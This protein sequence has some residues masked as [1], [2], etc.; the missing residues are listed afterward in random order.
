MTD[1]RRMLILGL[2]GG[3]VIAVGLAAEWLAHGTR[4]GFAAQRDLLT[5]WLIGAVGLVAWA[6]VPRS[7]IGPLLVGVGLTWFI[8]TVADPRTLPGQGAAALTFVYV[9]VLVHAVLTWPTGR[10]R[11]PL[12]RIFVI[13]GYLLA[14]F[15]PL[16]ERD[17]GLLVIAALL[18]LALA[19]QWLSQPPR[20]R[21]ARRP[22]GIVGLWL[23]FVLASK[24]LVAGYLRR[25]GVAYPGDPEALWQIALVVAAAVLAWSLIALERRRRAATDL[26]VSLEAVGSIPGAAVL[27]ATAGLPDE[28]ST[29]EALSRAVAMAERNHALQ[30]ELS[31]QATALE[32]SRRRLL[33]AEDEEREALEARL[34]AGPRARLADLR[35]RLDDARR[36]LAAGPSEAA[37]RLDRA[38]AQLAHALDELDELA[39]GLDPALLRE[40]GLAEALVDLAGR[41]PVPVDVAMQPLGVSEPGIERT[42]FY[43]ASEALAN[44][45]KHAKASRAW[46]SLTADEQAVALSVD[47][48][49][50]GPRGLASGSGLRGLRDRVETLGGV[51][52]IAGRPGGG[53]RLRVI[54]PRSGSGEA[55]LT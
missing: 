55:S 16:W 47:D 22:A 14:L 53:T 41:S 2:A 26:V 28:S 12:D 19:G 10:A 1:R 5:G 39:R 18:A 24:G 11:G 4:L 13:G 3:S 49:G 21:R 30:A 33:V 40:R 52:D 54:V 32:A 38:A 43:V 20:L 31:A 36:G 42:L 45:A 44:V 50:I 25:Q 15:P 7:R 51:I 8:G 17:T 6:R 48:D 23:A 37:A 46:L 9:G 34:R 29:R 27:A 35:L